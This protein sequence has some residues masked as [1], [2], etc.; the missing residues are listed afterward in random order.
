MLTDKLFFCVFH[1]LHRVLQIAWGTHV[2]NPLYFDLTPYRVSRIICSN[3]SV[4]G[5]SACVFHDSSHNICWP[6]NSLHCVT[7]FFVYFFSRFCQ[8]RKNKCLS[9]WISLS[10][11]FMCEIAKDTAILFLRDLVKRR[12]VLE[13]HRTLNVL[14]KFRSLVSYPG[15]TVFKC[16]TNRAFLSHIK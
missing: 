14:C 16:L 11:I 15:C 4:L 1:Y 6:R 5:P 13:S 9:Y 8:G 2:R 10:F 12:K 7:I 3:A